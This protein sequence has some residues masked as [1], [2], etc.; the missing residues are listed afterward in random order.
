MTTGSFESFDI[1]SDIQK[2]V[3]MG[4][5]VSMPWEDM[6]PEEAPSAYLANPAA[7]SRQKRELNLFCDFSRSLEI[8]LPP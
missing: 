2:A 5:S 6:G 7:L 1:L 3:C 8:C 4:E